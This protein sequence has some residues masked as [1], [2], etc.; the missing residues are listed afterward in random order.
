[1]LECAACDMLADCVTSCHAERIAVAPGWAVIRRVDAT[2]SSILSIFQCKHADACPGGAVASN[3]WK[4]R[5][6]EM[7]SDCSPGYT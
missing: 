5:R 4:L 2:N 7:E 3:R 1:V 6:L